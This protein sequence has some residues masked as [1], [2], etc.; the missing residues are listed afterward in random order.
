M[1]WFVLKSILL[2]FLRFHVIPNIFFS[3]D[4]SVV[5]SL[6]VCFL[7]RFHFS[8]PYVTAGGIQWMYTLRF[9]DIESLLVETEFALPN[10]C[11][12]PKCYSSSNISSYFRQLRIAKIQKKTLET[13]CSHFG[14]TVATVYYKWRAYFQN[15]LYLLL[16][17]AKNRIKAFFANILLV[18]LSGDCRRIFLQ[19]QKVWKIKGV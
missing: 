18:S 9:K 7:V 15:A 11:N 10:A 8:A 4:T 6:M 16:I 12:P 19:N 14:T 5:H 1:V 17:T 13:F 2:F 3:W